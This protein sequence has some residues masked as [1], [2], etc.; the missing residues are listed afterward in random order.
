MDPVVRETALPQVRGHPELMPET[1]WAQMPA[2]VHV[3]VTARTGPVTAVSDIP[4]G[5]NCRV[6]AILDTAAGS[7]FIK[8]VNNAADREVLL[9]SV[10]AGI[11]PRLRWH[12]SADGLTILCHDALTDA[13]HTH[14]GPDSYDL[15]RLAELLARSS[16]LPAPARLPAWADRWAGVATPDEA[17]LLQG[18]RLVHADINQHNAIIVNNR[19]WLVD[20]A[21]ATRGP[22]WADTAEAAV[23]A[24]EDD[25]S[26]DQ[27][28]AFATVVPAWRAAPP[29]NIQA[30]ADVRCRAWTEAVGAHDARHSNARH[31]A[32]AA[33][34]RD[35]HVAV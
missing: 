27:A 7:V 5:Y 3:A 28:E 31:Q 17:A 26:A 30:W 15:P 32:L 6:A 34:H 14:L 23:R 29:A 11:G 1:T 4:D 25:C 33:A 18:D 21:T 24:M 9:G 13:R 12:A 2:T 22:A 20:W 10:V 19:V 16:A 8:V 35:A